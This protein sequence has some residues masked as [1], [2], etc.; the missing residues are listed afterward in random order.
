[1]IKILTSILLLITTFSFAQNGTE[2]TLLGTFHPDGL[3]TTGTNI[4][5]DVWGYTDCNGNEYALLGSA[6]FV[7]F[8]DVTDPSNPTEINRFEG[9]NVTTWRDMKTYKNVAYAVSDNTSEG[10]LVFDLSNL[11]SEVIFA[12]Q[13]TDDFLRAHNI[14]VDEPN[15]RLYVVGSGAQRDGVII[16]DLTCDPLQPEL[17]ASVATLPAGYI[18]DIYVRDN[19]AYAS[20]GFPGF[21]VWDFN[22]PEQ[23]V[24]TAIL[25]TG[26]YNHSSWITDDGRYAVYAEEIPRGEPL[27]IIDLANVATGDI[28]VVSEFAFP[29]LAPDFTDATP[30]NPYIRGHYVVSSYYEDGLH[31]YDIS[32]PLH[33]TEV[34]YYDTY[35]DNDMYTG[36]SGN[37]GTYPYLP[38]GNLL[39][40]DRSYGLLVLKAENIDFEAVT[41]FN[42]V[43]VQ[44]EQSDTLLCADEPVL[45]S[46]AMA[47][48]TYQWTF[49]GE[50][51]VGAN[52]SSYLATGSGSYALMV[53]N[54]NCEGLSCE[55]IVGR[56]EQPEDLNLQPD[57]N[58]ALTFPAGVSDFQW[59]VDE[60]LVEGATNSSF[61]P[62][63]VIGHAFFATAKD[64]NGCFITSI[65]FIE[66]SN[67]QNFDNT[68]QI[69]IYPTII[70][71]QLQI[72]IDSPTNQDYQLQIFNTNGQLLHTQS[73]TTGVT[74][75]SLDKMTTGIYFVHIFNKNGRIVEKIIKRI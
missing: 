17:L 44:L 20:H 23:P 40:S 74:S 29:L 36:Y 10:L 32:D 52:E 69:S 18:H 33:P 51:I 21:A 49:E 60:E 6:A 68:T 1:M 45:L 71:N 75:L 53:S 63:V 39:A 13:I 61:L 22:Q 11:P 56:Y 42:Q 19:I 37:W 5:N 4:Y 65:E 3:P 48:D 14:F 24:L 73:I 67:T 2:M 9:G 64:I 62:D 70:S 16:Y 47:F 43:D 38:S 55:V 54:G 25:E 7:H 72:D 8:I 28:Q 12:N 30:H 46:T 35:P 66:V 41:P 58:G 31:V 26:G 34:A 50:N 15:G 27:G 57:E 59:Y